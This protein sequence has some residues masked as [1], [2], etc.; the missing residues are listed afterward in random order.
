MDQL[1]YA[2]GVLIT[3]YN[4]T[5]Q[6]LN[7][8][9]Q[10]CNPATVVREVDA[11]ARFASAEHE[12]AVTEAARRLARGKVKT[13]DVVDTMEIRDRIHT[14]AVYSL[15]LQL[16]VFSREGVQRSLDQAAFMNVSIGG[17]PRPYSIA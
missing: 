16:A 7:D 17:R 11:V 9:G 15:A 3:M 14:M 12:F 4:D 5:R 1:E 13:Q 10:P 8:T 6:V 2:G